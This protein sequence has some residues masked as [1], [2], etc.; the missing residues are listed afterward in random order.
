M[1]AAGSAVFALC[2]LLAGMKLLDIYNLRQLAGADQAQ[3]E[4]V[5][6]EYRRI[7]ATFPVAPTSTENLKTTMK[8][9]QDLQLHSASPDYLLIEVSKA[10]AEFP[11]LELDR[12]DWKI[13]KPAVEPGSKYAPPKP[14]VVAPVARTA[15]GVETDYQLAEISARVV[16]QR[17]PDLRAVTT[18]V[19][20][21][22]DKLKKSQRL[23]VISVRLPFSLT[24]ETSLRGDIGAERAVQETST[25][26]VTVGR[27]LGS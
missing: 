3:F 26:F 24:S 19:D 12:I 20:Q 2:A 27:R 10:L 25:F 23:E 6:A 15:T 1:I 22:V 11:Q 14:P 9:Y 4:S 8:R 17:R 7:T 13:G 21:F 18:V 16:S 5:S